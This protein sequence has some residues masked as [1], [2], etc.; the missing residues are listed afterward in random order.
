MSI[1]IKNEKEIASMRIGG[2]ILG[3][4]L[5]ALQ[6]KVAPGVTPLM[7]E[8]EAERLFKSYGATPGC[9]GYHG[10]PNILC[11]SVNEQVVHAIP[12][13]VPLEEGDVLSIDCVS[14]YDGLNTDSAVAVGVGQLSAQD[15]RLIKTCISAMWNGIDQVKPGNRIGDIS[16]AI[17][18]E[19]KRGSF[20]VVKEL[21]GHG[22]GYTMHEEPYVPNHGSRGQGPAL[23]PG[24]TLAIEPIISVGSPKIFELKDGWTLVTVDRSRS[25]QHEHTVLVTES[26]FE[27][28]TLRPEEMN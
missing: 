5:S 4:I 1:H 8:A 21:T 27:V 25:M 2:K 6:K 14:I 20:K 10:Y 26:G 24:M 22:I 9:K 23:K 13:D 19:V 15:E 28:L 7:L 3:E 16:N 17:E 18:Q 12:T 11:V